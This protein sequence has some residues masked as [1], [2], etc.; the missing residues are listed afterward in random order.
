MK[1]ELPEK[2]AATLFVPSRYKVFWGG[3]GGG[4]TKNIGRGLVVRGYQKK[5]KALCAREI[6]KS[7]ADSVHAVLEQEIIDVGLKDFYEIQKTSIRSRHNGTEF[8]FAGLRHN[9][10]NIKSIPDIDVAWVEE[11]ETVSKAS[12]RVL[13][14]T[15]RAP[16]SEI[17]L[18]FNPDLEESDI[19]Q[20]FVVSPPSDAIIV[21]MNWRDNPWFPEVL[22]KEMDDL[23]RRDF[24]EYEHVYEGKPKHAVEGAIFAEELRMAAESQRFTKVPIA[25]GIPVQTFWDLGESD[26]TAIWFVQLIGMEYRIV[27]YYQCSGVKMEHYIDVLD[28]RGYKYEEHCLPHD[29]DHDQLAAK[30]TIRKQLEQALEDNPALGKKVRIVPR[31]PRKALGIEAARKIFGQCIFDKEKTSDGIQCLRHYAFSKDMET[32]RISKEPKHDIWSHGADA[33][34]CFAQH[35]KKPQL[36]SK[37]DPFKSGRMQGSWMAQ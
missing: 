11:A 29:A 14:P 22:R 4:K 30:T 15:I 27:D 16:G 24:K 34:L 26:N 37:P 21:N 8:L 31:I 36:T 23:R 19:Y 35:F 20:D 9:I 5:Q 18:S 2:M 1:I 10:A 7:I 13:I 6:Q 33:F 17:W 12:M 25:A 32:G 3:R 28:K